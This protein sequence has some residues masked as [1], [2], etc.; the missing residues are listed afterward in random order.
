MELR[1][2]V[3]VRV[4]VRGLSGQR[5]DVPTS[6]EDSLILK[7][8]LSVV[9][10][11]SGMLVMPWPTL[12]WMLEEEASCSLYLKVSWYLNF[13]WFCCSFHLG[14]SGVRLSVS[15]GSE[16]LTVCLGLA[17]EQEE[18]PEEE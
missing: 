13:S 5:K 10:E 15:C 8:E 1:S 16:N 2:G 17:E 9:A 12:Q 7:L 14:L 3:L 11:A 4:L 6:F 18:E